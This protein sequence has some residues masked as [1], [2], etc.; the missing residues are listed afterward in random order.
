V[1]DGNDD[2]ARLDEAVEEALR[3]RAQVDVLYD[4]EARRAV[5]GLAALLRFRR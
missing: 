5:D 4:D 2:D 1:A 3:Q